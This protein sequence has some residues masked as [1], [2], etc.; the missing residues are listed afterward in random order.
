MEH[1][2][3]QKRLFGAVE[4]FLRR[5]MEG[6]EDVVAFSNQVRSPLFPFLSLR[7]FTLL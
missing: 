4:S 3:H 7:D 6:V 1:Q 2:R 5:K